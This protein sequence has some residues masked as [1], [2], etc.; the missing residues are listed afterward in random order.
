VRERTIGV[1]S[2][3]SE[4]AGAY[5]QRERLILR[6]VCAYSAVALDNASAYRQLD[7]TR[8]QLAAAGQAEREARRR[9]EEAIQVKSEFL[10]SI[11][12]D[13][14]TPLASLHGFL[15]TLLVKADQLGD[16]DRDRYLRTA[17]GQSRQVGRLASELLD[18][19]R[20]ESGAV[21]LTLERFSL[22]ELT[23][24]VCRKFELSVR[25]RQHRL[26]EFF[27]A[28]LPDVTADIGMIE[29][30]LSNLLD[31]AVHYAPQGSEI[32]V[33]LCVAGTGVRA[34]VLDTGPGVPPALR[35]TLF[36]Q[37]AS[38]ARAHRPGGSGLGLLVVQRLLQRHG[39]DIE[40]FERPGYGAAFGFTLP[41]ARDDD[42][43]GDHSRFLR[44]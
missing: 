1:L 38:L 8:L 10:A 22:S 23:Q 34:Q 26:T 35:A 33:E 25:K 43:A 4:R 39:S 36:K 16:A 27:A 7:Q 15:E 18:L 21:E 3:Q 13:L 5:G 44:D 9:A 6:T 32:R 37:P 40:M 12:H 20:L 41:C 11:S 31:N 2:I 19:A 24:D 14:R 29:R 17:I 28:D 42:P 30:V